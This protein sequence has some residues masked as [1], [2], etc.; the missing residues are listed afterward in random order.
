[1]K[2]CSVVTV[3][4]LTADHSSQK[5]SATLG[6]GPVLRRVTLD[7][8]HLPAVGYV[9]MPIELERHSVARRAIID[10]LL[11][12]YGGEQIAVPI[13]LSVEVRSALDRWPS[14]PSERGAAIAADDAPFALVRVRPEGDAL[15]VEFEYNGIPGAVL[16]A[17]GKEDEFLLFRFDTGVH[18][19]QLNEREQW[20]FLRFLGDAVKPMV[21][22]G[23]KLLV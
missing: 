14:E 23:R 5:G 13:D 19:W 15:A 12:V 11:R 2:S 21:A 20:G 7:L 16:V 10:L 9:V 6:L 3:F 8:S 1:M 4:E 22:K 18:P 17:L